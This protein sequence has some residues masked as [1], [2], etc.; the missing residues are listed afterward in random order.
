M[1]YGTV[2]VFPPGTT[3]E[4]AKRMVAWMRREMYG[5]SIP[6]PHEF[7]PKWGGPVWY[8]P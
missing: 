3:K 7:D 6:D 5:A 8:I 2:V 4:E 1:E